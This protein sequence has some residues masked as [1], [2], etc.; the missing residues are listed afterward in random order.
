MLAQFSIWP[1]DNP[2]MSKEVALAA[3][4]LEEMGCQYEVG[5]MGTTIQG[6]WSEVMNAIQAC[7]EALRKTHQ[8]VLTS[9]TID[10]DSVQ[11]QELGAATAK[12]SSDREAAR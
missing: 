8:R 12:V 11:T 3:D 1:L 6:D 2:H 4:V 9:I 7:H 5:P 10:D